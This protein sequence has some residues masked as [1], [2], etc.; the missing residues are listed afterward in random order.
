MLLLSRD[1]LQD[2]DEID[3]PLPQT[4]G[5]LFM[6]VS[7]LLVTYVAALAYCHMRRLSDTVV[8]IFRLGILAYIFPWLLLVAFCASFYFIY[9]GRVITPAQVSLSTP[10]YHSLSS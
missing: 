2:L 7:Q 3:V 10:R 5:E 4:A 9:I 8:Y 6:N 1:A